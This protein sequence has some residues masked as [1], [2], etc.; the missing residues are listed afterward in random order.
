MLQASENFGSDFR[1]DDINH[2]M[3]ISFSFLID[4]TWNAGDVITVRLETDGE[5]TLYHNGA[6]SATDVRFGNGLSKIIFTEYS[7]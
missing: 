1:G 2:G 5:G 6:I 3:N 4:G 7:D